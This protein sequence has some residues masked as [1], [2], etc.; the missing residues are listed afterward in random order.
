VYW[1][2][3]GK[4]CFDAGN[5]VY[6]NGSIWVAVGKKLGAS[7][8]TIAYSTDGKTWQLPTQT[9]LFATSGDRIDWNGTY[10]TVYGT[11]AT[12]NKATST[13]G[14]VWTMTNDATAAPAVVLN[15]TSQYLKIVSN[16]V[17]ASP[18]NLY[19]SSPVSIS[20]M[21]VLTKF[22][23]NRSNE[24]STSIQP[25]SIAMGE[26][27]NTMAY[28]T[29]GIQWNGLGKSV[30]TTRG[31]KAAWNGT[32]WVAVGTG[33]FWCATSYDGVQ[34]T[35]VSNTLFTEAYDVAWN[36]TVFVAVGEGTTRIAV[37]TD[38]TNWSAVANSTTIFTLRATAIEWTGK[39]WLAYGSGGN[40]TANSTNVL[41]TTWQATTTPNLCVTDMSSAIQ[42]AYGNNITS[43]PSSTYFYA[44][45]NI[46]GFE[47]YRA[48]DGSMNTYYKTS[49]A[50]STTNG[51]KPTATQ[52]TYT[53]TIGIDTGHRI[54]IDVS[55]SITIKGYHIAFPTN[56][57][58]S[59][60][61]LREW[62]LIGIP[63][64][65]TWSNLLAGGNI[66]VLLHRG[67][68]NTP[69]TTTNDVYVQYVN[70]MNNTTAFR[71]YVLLLTQSFYTDVKIANFDMYYE[72]ANTYILP[73]YTRPIVTR[74]YVFH[75][76]PVINEYST[77]YIISGLLSNSVFP[78][79]SVTAP[80]TYTSFYDTN[81]Q[82]Q[83]FNRTI[84]G[85][86]TRSGNQQ[87]VSGY[88]FDGNTMFATTT[89]GGVLAMSSDSANAYLEFDSSFNGATLSSG[90]TTIRGC[91]Y[92]R[93]YVLLGGTGGSVITYNTLNTG[94]PST[95][96]N[97]NADGLFTTVNGL[98][99]NSGY[100]HV[101]TPNAIYLNAG[102]K[103]S[104]ITPK[105]KNQNVNGTSISFDLYKP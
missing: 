91:C 50:F 7:Q 28:S 26:G 40:T 15:N 88:G 67:A 23:W 102:D 93:N 45:W 14:M 30:F 9:N 42:T 57:D 76:N 54:I 4:T 55:Q 2:G 12:Y 69:P 100:G 83:F 41:A 60:N 85:A 3:V 46:S 11:D 61:I 27:N 78:I 18:D 90:L 36:G 8:K 16:Q 31:N 39:A 70:L 71:V 49:N 20:N 10:W 53:N 32:V 17:V 59:N 34:W 105:T 99:S 86:L 80:A 22:A 21:S 19:W 82:L 13:D 58:P 101:Y 89:G 79:N 24:G 81:T 92:N 95:W 47:A 72:N 104:V 38:G 74:D 48:I 75:P 5:D 64:N 25:L 96:Y 65:N 43:N 37:S 33:G 103:L 62:S 77:P 1:T 52:F 97:T 35:G 87:T 73:K 29:D 44:D 63:G 51:R 94:A 84:N 98:A 56:N 6:W 68:F 66:G